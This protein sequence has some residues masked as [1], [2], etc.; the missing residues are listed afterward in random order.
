MNRKKMKIFAKR[1]EFA[2]NAII[3]AG[4]AGAG[5]LLINDGHIVF[6]NATLAVV[7]ALTGVVMYAVFTWYLMELEDAGSEDKSDGDDG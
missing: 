7:I 4:L 3:G 6:E 1:V 5:A 2:S